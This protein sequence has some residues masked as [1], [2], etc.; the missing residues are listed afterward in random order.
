M[1]T[2]R[3]SAERKGALRVAH[4]GCARMSAASWQ[5]PHAVVWSMGGVHVVWVIR[6]HAS[7]AAGVGVIRMHDRMCAMSMMALAVA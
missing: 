3:R 4:A 2:A 6:R 1:L 7:H 5:Q